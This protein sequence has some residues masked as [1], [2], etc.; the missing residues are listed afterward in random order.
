MRFSLLMLAGALLCSTLAVAQDAPKV[1]FE[2][3]RSL[4]VPGDTVELLIT[5]TRTSPIWIPG[6]A[7]LQLQSFESESYEPLALEKCI[8]EGEAVKIAPG[9]HSLSF[10]ADSAHSGRILRA[11][12][13]Y[14]WGCT[15]SGPLSGARCQ[16]FATGWS[17]NFRVSRKADGK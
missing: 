12:V 2:A 3:S 15:S 9:T 4:Y 16:D 13:A 14:G 7:A 5:N 8:S 17:R 11:G 1:K 6:C 10:T